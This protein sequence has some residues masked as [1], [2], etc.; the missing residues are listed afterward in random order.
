MSQ[1]RLLRSATTTSPVMRA[2]GMSDIDIDYPP[3]IHQEQNIIIQKNTQKDGMSPQK[4]ILLV[5]KFC[6]SIV[7]LGS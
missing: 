2:D 5:K 3:N 7:N 6:L 1:M 4:K